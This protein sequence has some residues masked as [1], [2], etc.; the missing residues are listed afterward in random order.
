MNTE[1][2]NKEIQKLIDKTET[3]IMFIDEI[4]PSNGD[5]EIGRFLS[6]VQQTKVQEH[7]NYLK[8]LKP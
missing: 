1:E 5:T 2:K 3:I 8:L 7:S 6:L 4:Y